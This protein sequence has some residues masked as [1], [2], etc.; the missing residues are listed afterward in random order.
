MRF[1][2]LLLSVLLIILSKSESRRS[3]GVT[4]PSSMHRSNNMDSSNNSSEQ[5]GGGAINEKQRTLGNSANSVHEKEESWDPSNKLSHI[6][7]SIV[8]LDRYP[9][10][11]S[12][13]DE[14]D[15][16]AIEHALEQTLNDVRQQR[17][18]VLQRRNGIRELVE[19]YNN[20]LASPSAI[21]DD[22]QASSDSKNDVLQISS[23]FQPKSWSQLKDVLSDEAFEVVYA[24]LSKSTQQTLPS[25]EDVIRGK[26]AVQ[27]D[28][29]L[30]EDWMSQECFDVYSF[31]LLSKDFC[32][33][34]RHT[35]TDL[36]KL[37]ESSEF[38]SLLLGRRPI[39]FDTVGL[40]WISDMLLHMF[41]LPISRH[42]FA[43]TEKLLSSED[44]SN[45]NNNN[46]KDFLNWRQGYVAGYSANP[47]SD[48][49]VTR[50]RLVPHSD[51]SEVTLNCCLG[52]EDFEGGN[53]QFYGL[54]GTPN[55][56]KLLGE[57][58]RPDVGRAVIHAGRHL[59]AV[60]EVTAGNRYAL[61]VWTRSWGMRRL[62]CPCCHLN[63]RMDASCICDSR[64]N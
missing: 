28:P 5:L 21:H 54:R 51:D 48:R 37:G 25:V 39:D 40:N 18:Q 58:E 60:S 49:A 64:W 36:S 34:L 42:L 46:T 44:A 38:C 15:I 32:S 22:S 41:I 12:R 6:L 45:D 61:I 63:R 55:E 19:K 20:A 11:L 26:F 35:I 59:H 27:L 33:R 7:H 56:G 10:Y 16:A 50:H 52:E 14:S 53:V 29:A 13:Y 23:L 9:N 47:Q 31:Q 3:R 4:Y 17:K 30:L 43:T 62:T 2:G 57:V 8:G 24:S 1:C